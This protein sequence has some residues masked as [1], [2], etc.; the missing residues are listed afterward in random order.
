MGEFSIGFI[1]GVIASIFV[2]V[3]VLVK[4]FIQTIADN[5]RE[6]RIKAECDAVTKAYDRMVN[7][8]TEWRV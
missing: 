7:K 1:C 3:L 6:R 5:A 4:P 8:V 2:Q